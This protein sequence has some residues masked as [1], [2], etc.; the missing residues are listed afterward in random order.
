VLGEARVFIKPEFAISLYDRCFVSTGIN[1]EPYARFEGNINSTQ[2]EYGI[3]GGITAGAFF[4]ASIFG[5]NLIDRTWNNLINIPEYEIAS[6]SYE[7]EEHI[8]LSDFVSQG[9]VYSSTAPIITFT[10]SND[11]M[12]FYI[13]RG[14]EIEYYSLTS[15]F[16]IN[17]INQPDETFQLPPNRFLQ[18]IAINNNGTILYVQTNGVP[19]SSNYIYQY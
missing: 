18:D 17:G 5:F 12:H 14:S 7:L 19:F 16:S 6:G 4:N 15:P 1:V 11:G 8:M 3:Y 9:V 2:Y 10:F 13:G